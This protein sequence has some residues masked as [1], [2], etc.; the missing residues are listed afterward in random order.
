MDQ[1]LRELVDELSDFCTNPEFAKLISVEG[2]PGCGKTLFVRAGLERF[3][4]EYSEHEEYYDGE[5]VTLLVSSLSHAQDKLF[6]NAWRPLLRKLLL[7]VAK[8]RRLK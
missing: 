7:L 6:L 3:N 2:P 1:P 8:R 4:Q 5:A